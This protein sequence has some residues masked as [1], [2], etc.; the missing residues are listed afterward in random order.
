[1]GNPRLHGEL[2]LF[3]RALTQFLLRGDTEPLV[4]VDWTKVG[5]QHYALSAS[6][7]VDGRALPIYW[8]VYDLERLSNPTIQKDFLYM[9]NILLPAGCRPVIVTDAGFR[10]SW[11]Q[12][13][14]KLGWDYVG[15]LGGW[16][17][18]R[19]E[20]DGWRRGKTICR[21]AGD[22]HADLGMCLVTK[23]WRAERRVILAK[24]F[25][26][27]PTR[28]KAR[29]RRSDRGRGNKR[30]VQRAKEPW[31]LV[32]SL[33]QGTAADIIRIYAK[34]MQIEENY[35]DAKNHRF[36]W[37]FRHARATTS[38]RY[39]VLLLIGSLGMVAL[40]LIGQ[41]A[42]TTKR[43]LRYQANTIRKRR[44]LSLFFLGKALVQR[45]DLIS[46]GRG[47]LE[48]ALV[49]VRAKISTV[50]LVLENE[51]LGIP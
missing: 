46:L 29:L 6:V 15:R 30:A 44:V 19:R 49:E 27:N 36:G 28:P 47:S 51:E 3:F 10:G 41:A 33:Q 35:R 43:H 13:V 38:F 32:T 1:M 14:R 23:A 48:T 42:E 8:E 31:L 37:S 17:L 18:I 22:H 5:R 26:R 7:P 24:R 11:F 45:R 2:H 12:I 25:Q 20:G 21:E 4:L 39:E 50:P 9:L 16:A 34:R 40:M